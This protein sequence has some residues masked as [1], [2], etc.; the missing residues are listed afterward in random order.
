MTPEPARISVA[1]WKIVLFRRLVNVRLLV[2]IPWG[3]GVV[4][5]IGEM[6]ARR[7]HDD[8]SRLGAPARAPIEPEMSE[9]RA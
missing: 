1:R 7:R 6:A 8:A 2:G 4:R 5:G 3:R 9:V